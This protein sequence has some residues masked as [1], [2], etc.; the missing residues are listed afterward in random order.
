MC[1]CNIIDLYQMFFII[2]SSSPWT[3]NLEKEWI[4]WEQEGPLDQDN[5]SSQMRARDDEEVASGG[6]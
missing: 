6:Q 2:D 3:I 1:Q 4:F 5:T